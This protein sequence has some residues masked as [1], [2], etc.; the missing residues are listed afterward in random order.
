VIGSMVFPFRVLPCGLVAAVSGCAPRPVARPP[1]KGEARGAMPGDSQGRGRLTEARP[2][3]RA[4]SFA[5]R[6]VQS[7]IGLDCSRG[8]HRV[9]AMCRNSLSLVVPPPQPRMVGLG[10]P[11]PPSFLHRQAHRSRVFLVTG[12]RLTTLPPLPDP[13]AALHP[14]RTRRRIMG[15]RPCL[16]I[17]FHR[18]ARPRGIAGGGDYVIAGDL[19]SGDCRTS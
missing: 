3:E 8:Q 1:T 5:A 11:P 2:A 10:P 19:V 6:M 4:R 9:R 7:G 14:V 13:D 17:A 18:R 15:S 12:S 16:P